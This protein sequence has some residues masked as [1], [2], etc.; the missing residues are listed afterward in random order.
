MSGTSFNTKCPNCR[1]DMESYSDWKPI[2]L[3]RHDCYVCGFSMWPQ[4]YFM[5]LEELNEGRG[6]RE[7]RSLKKLPKQNKS[8][9]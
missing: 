2:D 5:N 3:V 1:K 9:I 8:C 4:I 7:L 6:E